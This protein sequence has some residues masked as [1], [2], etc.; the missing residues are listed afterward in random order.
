MLPVRR[1]VNQNPHRPL[2]PLLP[3][4]VWLLHRIFRVELQFPRRFLWQICDS[5]MIF[6]PVDKYI[7]FATL[8]SFMPYTSC[9]YT[10][11]TSG[12]V[13]RYSEN[14][15]ALPVATPILKACS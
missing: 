4:P 10:S 2:L 11:S 1:P 13:A 6:P 12:L 7:F 8:L 3:V 15:L 9:L 5:H 14:A